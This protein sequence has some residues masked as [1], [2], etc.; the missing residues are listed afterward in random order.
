MTLLIDAAQGWVVAGQQTVADR[1]ELARSEVAGDA[2]DILLDAG[3]LAGV[4]A[5]ATLGWVLV[6]V[7]A[8]SALAQVVQPSVSA[9]ALGG[10]HLL[11]GLGLAWWTIRRI[12]QRDD[13]R[14]VLESEVTDA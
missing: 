12:R 9:V 8:A 4:V 7:G 11:V 5:L 2:R 14:S 6:T 10:P 3:M 1:V 13:G